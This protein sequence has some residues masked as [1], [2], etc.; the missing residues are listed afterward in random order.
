MPHP[1]KAGG[2]WKRRFHT[3]NT[4][5]FC[6]NHFRGILKHNIHRSFWIYCM[7]EENSIRRKSKDYRNAMFSK[8]SV[9]K[10][11]I[12]PHENE[13]PA[14]SHSSGLKIVF[15]NLRFRDGL[16]WTLG[17]KL[18]FQISSTLCEP[19]LKRFFY[20]VYKIANQNQNSSKVATQFPRFFSGWQS[21]RD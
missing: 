14:F 19:R 5:V 7:L 16:E 17:I 13:K 9:F 3:E 15:E 1:H 12:R 10:T 8:N 21:H 2:I 11:Y 20:F 18:R 4:N 6:P